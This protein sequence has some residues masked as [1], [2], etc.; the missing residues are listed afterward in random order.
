[1]VRGRRKGGVTE[2]LRTY[3]GV[4]KRSDGGAT[5]APQV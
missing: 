4:R 3:E 1:M 5:E 2:T